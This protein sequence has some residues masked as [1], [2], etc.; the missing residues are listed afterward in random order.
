MLTKDIPRE[1]PSKI[2]QDNHTIDLI[3]GTPPNK[4]PYQVSQAQQEEI[5]RQVNE[6]VENKM[7]RLSSFSFC[8]PILLK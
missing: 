1:L 2:I 3:L 6:L 4:P 8:F 7:I 5:M